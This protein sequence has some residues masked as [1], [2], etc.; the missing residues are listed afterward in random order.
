MHEASHALGRWRGQYGKPRDVRLAD[1]IC[2]FSYRE[3][4]SAGAAH[5]AERALARNGAGRGDRG[6][7]G[8][9]RG[10]GRGQTFGR[11]GGRR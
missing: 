3:G 6:F 1:G 7:G 2:A 4:H 10:S 5:R 8:N 9:R 11:Q